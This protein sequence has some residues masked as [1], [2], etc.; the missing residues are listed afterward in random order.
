[1]R[2]REAVQE[3]DRADTRWRLADIEA[4]RAQVPD[5]QNGATVAGAAAKLLPPNW[6]PAT[7]NGGLRVAPNVRLPAEVA[8]QLEDERKSLGAALELARRLAEL[9]RG[10][11]PAH[12]RH[13]DLKDLLAQQQQLRRVAALLYHEAA[14]QMQA[15]RADQAARACLAVLNTGRAVGD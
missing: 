15:G 1:D 9:P 4:D 8:R 13:E 2:M 7:L 3:V 14:R 12:P 6:T 5:E 10:R 11:F